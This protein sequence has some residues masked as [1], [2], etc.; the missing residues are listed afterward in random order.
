MLLR[1]LL[2]STL[3]VMFSSCGSSKANSQARLAS[4][5]SETCD[6]R[7]SNSN[8]NLIAEKAKKRGPTAPNPGFTTD[9][10]AQPDVNDTL[11]IVTTSDGETIIGFPGGTKENGE[12]VLSTEVAVTDIEGYPYDTYQGQQ[13]NCAPRAFETVTGVYNPY[14]ESSLDG[15]ETSINVGG[16]TFYPRGAGQKPEVGD[17]IGYKPF[18]NRNGKHAA[19]V[20]GFDENGNAIVA[21]GWQSQ[22]YQTVPIDGIIQ[23]WHEGD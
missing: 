2:A 1:V 4:S 7:Y 15:D 14:L 16:R 13:G 6:V 23:S 10:N 11:P 9:P 21:T 22:P 20:T 18:A 17:V 3:A 5:S 8:T 12:P 19:V